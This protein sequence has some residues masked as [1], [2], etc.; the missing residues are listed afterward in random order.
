M[1]GCYGGGGCVGGGVEGGV[2]EG[3]CEEGEG[4][5]WRRGGG[6]VV[7]SRTNE[8]REGGFCAHAV[9]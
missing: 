5:R 7:K 2:G 9:I 4:G 6:W 3:E 1:C 8:A